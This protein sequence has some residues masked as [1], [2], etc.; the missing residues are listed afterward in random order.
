M[1]ITVDQDATLV[2]D[3]VQKQRRIG[4]HALQVGDVN[5]TAGD[6]FQADGELE[7]CRGTLVGERDQQVEV[8]ARVLVAPR[9]RTVEHGKANIVLGAER[10]V[11][12]SNQLVG[13]SHAGEATAT[14]A[15]YGDA[16]AGSRTWIY[17]LGG[18]DFGPEKPRV[19]W[20]FGKSALGAVSI[21]IGTFQQ[22]R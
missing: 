8:R 14:Y 16:P 20:V 7:P 10:A 2:E 5:L 11:K 21:D 19:Y 9:Q 12:V 17:R 6:W 13:C 3:P 1:P 18:A 4:L 15:R 22:F